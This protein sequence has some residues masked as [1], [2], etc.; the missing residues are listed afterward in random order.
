MARLVLV[1]GMGPL[2]FKLEDGS[3]LSVCTCGL[4][5]TFPLCSGKHVMIQDEDKRTVYVYNDNYERLGEVKYIYTI[6]GERI[7]PRNIKKLKYSS[8]QA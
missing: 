8:G 6:D 1:N 3:T 5:K 7:N 4:S 2:S